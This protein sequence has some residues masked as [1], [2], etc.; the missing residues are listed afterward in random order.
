MLDVVEFHHRL[1]LIVGERQP[2]DVHDLEPLVRLE[3]EAR[4]VWCA[5]DPIERGYVDALRFGGPDEWATGDPDHH[6]GEWYR[7]AMAPYLTPTRA[8]RAADLLRRRLPDLGWSPPEARRLALGRELH[9]LIERHACPA[10]LAALGPKVALG[11]RG[12]LAQEDVDLAL[13]RC[14]SLRR[15]SFRHHQDLVPVVENA[16]EV[17]EAAATKPDH[18]LL[19]LAS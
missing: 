10:S 8:F 19:L 18:V 6:V 5:K 4:R 1:D 3:R 16:Y 2:F 13:D 17:L 15:E 12:W 11:Q 9:S 7:L 14:R